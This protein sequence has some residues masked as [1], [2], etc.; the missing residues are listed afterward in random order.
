MDFMSMKKQEPMISMLKVF[1]RKWEHESKVFGVDFSEMLNLLQAS[2]YKSWYNENDIC[3]DYKEWKS[4]HS[5]VK[6]VFLN[7]YLEEEIF[8]EQHEGFQIKGRVG[9]G[10]M[11]KAPLYLREITNDIFFYQFNYFC[12]DSLQGR[13]SRSN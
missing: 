4:Y 8:V 10:K 7:G 2:R 6:S 9:A 5:D 11:A 3:L 12:Y 1:L 13:F